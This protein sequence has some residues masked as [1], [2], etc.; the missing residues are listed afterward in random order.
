MTFTTGGIDIP[1]E[2]NINKRLKYI[3]LSISNTGV[4]VSLP[5]NLDDR[6]IL[7]VLNSKSKWICEH[8]IKYK[9]MEH[10]NLERKWQTGEK[11]LYRVIIHK[12]LGLLN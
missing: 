3:R 4:K 8:Y 2:T 5:K 12:L 7:A 11:L 9:S 1:V 10:D 6:S